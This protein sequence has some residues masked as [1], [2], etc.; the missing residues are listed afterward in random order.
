[1][2]KKKLIHFLPALDEM[3]G[4]ETMLQRTVP[5][6]TDFKHVFV[7]AGPL[8]KFGK[9]LKQKY[10]TY[11]LGYKSFY[12]FFSSLFK[13]IEI[14]KKEQPNVITTYLIHADLVGR[15]AAKLAG[16]YK[17]VCFNRGSLLNWKYLRFFDYLTKSFV[18]HYLTNSFTQR[19]RLAKEL[20]VNTNRVTVIQNGLNA[21]TLR[22][23]IKSIEIKRMLNINSDIIIIG[24]IGRLRHRKGL[25]TLL[26][27]FAQ[28]DSEKIKLVIVGDGPQKNELT[29]LSG[30]L[31]ISN[32]TIFT[33]TK[34]DVGNYYQIFD[35][36]VFPSHEEG[37]PNSLIEAL[38]TEQTI[39]CTNIHECR[40]VVGNNAEFFEPG[41]Y[42]GLAYKLKK[43]IN[44]PQKRIDLSKKTKTRF[45]MRFTI[46]HT[47][48]K[49]NQFYSRF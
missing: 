24:Y 47:V 43:M 15:V 14:I 38:A 26:K 49:L 30:S 34:N 20:M 33:G 46:N 31:G 42:H 40:E 18:D 21:A 37:M 44:A 36:F 16:N 10:P 13:L 19:R 48:E 25:T 6:M 11:S 17:V 29:S 32:K 39:I 27:A 23:N 35:I 9:T 28:I 5:L 22:P 1:M 45:K 7:S 8:G 2:S 41:D 12:D 3:G 4:T